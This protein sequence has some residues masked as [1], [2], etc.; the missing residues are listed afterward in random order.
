MPLQMPKP[1]NIDA[2]IAKLAALRLAPRSAEA[3]AELRKALTNKVDYVVQRAAEFIREYELPD[4]EMDLARAFHRLTAGGDKSFGARTAIVSAMHD[5]RAN[6]PEVYL[7]GLRAFG[8]VVPG[9][10]D[11]AAAMRGICAMALVVTGDPSGLRH[12]TDLLMDK[13]VPARAGAVRALASSGEDG[14]ALV[15]RL[16]LHV[17]DPE[18][19]VL[20]DVLSGLIQLDPLNSLP[21]V[22]QYLDDSD[23]AVA[24]AAAIALGESRR[25]EALEILHK[26]LARAL[27]ASTRRP[28]LLAIAITRRPEAVTILLEQLT[29]LRADSAKH[30]LEALRIYRADASLC[31]K[32]R[33]I[34]ENRKD[35]TLREEFD[36][37]FKE[38]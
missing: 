16:K 18:T 13:H 33:R 29:T 38:Q 35:T 12:A 28:L 15:L 34:V 31:D 17:G 30:V 19:E 24:D 11:P 9:M 14:A 36:K 8:S 4:F 32:V 22:E 10:I 23:E 37:S 7:A 5:L 26:R 2:I 3:A 21:L 27:T 25:P 1:S 20:G 6:V